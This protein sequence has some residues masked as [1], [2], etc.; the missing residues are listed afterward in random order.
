MP[1]AR[2]SGNDQQIVIVCTKITE[3]AQ[4]KDAGSSLSSVGNVC[5]FGYNFVP[6]FLLGV[7]ISASQAYPGH[8]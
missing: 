4:D 7:L 8:G 1:A 5:S 6:L 3:T 2:K